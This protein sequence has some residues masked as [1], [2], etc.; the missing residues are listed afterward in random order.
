MGGELE[1]SL[2]G[3]LAI[4]GTASRSSFG[5]FSLFRR[6]SLVAVRR[7][8]CIQLPCRQNGSVGETE[9]SR[10]ELEREVGLKVSNYAL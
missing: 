6:A 5:S 7:S 4:G 3:W 9:A 1:C 10:T 2:G 8:S